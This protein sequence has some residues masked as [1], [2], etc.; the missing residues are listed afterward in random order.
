MLRF[1]GRS[2]ACTK[3]LLLLLQCCWSLRQLVGTYQSCCCSS[4]CQFTGDAELQILLDVTWCRDMEQCI[5]MA[6]ETR[7][8]IL[9]FTMTFTKALV[10]PVKYWRK[11]TCGEDYRLRISLRNDFLKI[12]LLLET[13]ELG[14]A[15]LGQQPSHDVLLVIFFCPFCWWNTQKDKLDKMIKC[16]R[17]KAF[18]YQ[19]R[20]KG[21]QKRKEPN[22]FST[23]MY[24]GTSQLL[25]TRSQNL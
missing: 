1:L 13:S 11:G 17:W 21:I 7:P 20:S 15:S 10:A 3:V 22:V 25:L 2:S 6:C 9:N 16:P 12:S 19:G 23:E 18:C 5:G 8:P 24:S 4:I 14:T